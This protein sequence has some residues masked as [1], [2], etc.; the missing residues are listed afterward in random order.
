MRRMT[1]RPEPAAVAKLGFGRANAVLEVR[2]A[3]T[4][5]SSVAKRAV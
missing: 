3:D 2:V 4:P 5:R 1:R